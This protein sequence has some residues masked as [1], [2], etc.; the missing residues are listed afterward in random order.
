MRTSVYLDHNATTPLRTQAADAMREA[1]GS[2]G[3]P[4]SVHRHG[5]LARKLVED[6]REQVARLIGTDPANVIFTGSGTEANALA[7]RG[8]LGL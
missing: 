4:S 8:A 2:F 5:R 3:N 1:M 6:A 7:L